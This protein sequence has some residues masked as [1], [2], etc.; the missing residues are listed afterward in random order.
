MIR[1]NNFHEMLDCKQLQKF[2]ENISLINANILLQLFSPFTFSFYAYQNFISDKEE[3][4]IE[5]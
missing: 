4:I 3:F 5:E 1:V 2:L